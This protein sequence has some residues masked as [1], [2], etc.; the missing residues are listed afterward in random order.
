MHIYIYMC[1]YIYRERLISIRYIDIHLCINSNRQQKS[2]F[3]IVHNSQGQTK[4]YSG[5]FLT[6]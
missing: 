2:V 5:I 6:Y 4:N 3:L 1:V